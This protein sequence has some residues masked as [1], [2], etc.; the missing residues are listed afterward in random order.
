MRVLK[1]FS[2]GFQGERRLFSACKLGMHGTDSAGLID[3]QSLQQPAELLGRKLAYL[4]FGFGPLE[5]GIFQAFV[6]KQ[7]ADPVPQ[8][9]F[10][11]FSYSVTLE[12]TGF[13][14]KN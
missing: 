5:A 12:L 14:F 7:K 8:E 10:R 11:F 13:V 1:D 2:R 3:G 9:L 4:F 6:Q